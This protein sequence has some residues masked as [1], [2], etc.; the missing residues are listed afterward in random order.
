M[1]QTLEERPDGREGSPYKYC[2][3][4]R[5]RLNA[6]VIEI[7]LSFRIGSRFSW[8]ALAAIVELVQPWSNRKSFKSAAVAESFTIPSPMSKLVVNAAKAQKT[9]SWKKRKTRCGQLNSLKRALYAT[10]LAHT[11]HTNTKMHKKDAML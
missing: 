4:S 10:W 2:T 6:I 8:N 9:R 3:S 11:H 5:T 7:P 1:R